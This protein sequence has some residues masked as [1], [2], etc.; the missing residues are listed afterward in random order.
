MCILLGSRTVEGGDRVLSVGTTVSPVARSSV[1][2]R[3]LVNIYIETKANA[4][5]LDVQLSGLNL[6]SIVVKQDTL[7]ISIHKMPKYHQKHILLYISTVIKNNCY[8]HWN[9]F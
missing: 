5:L 6:I 8:V 3:R 2:T 7:Q 9:R 1:E 4:L